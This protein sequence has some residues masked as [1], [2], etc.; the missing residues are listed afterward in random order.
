LKETRRMYPEYL[1]DIYDDMG[2]V[3]ARL[4]Q[5]SSLAL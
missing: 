5:A 2:Y 3:H 1:C 4:I